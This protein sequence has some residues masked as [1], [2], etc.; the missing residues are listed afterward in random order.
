M[1]LFKLKSLF[2]K[3]C[4][5]AFLADD[6]IGICLFPN[7]S[8]FLKKRKDGRIKRETRLMKKHSFLSYLFWTATA[9]LIGITASSATAAAAKTARRYIASAGT[10]FTYEAE[11]LPYSVIEKTAI[12]KPALS[13][14]GYLA[15]D[16][17]TGEIILEKN[18]SKQFPIASITK[19]MTALVSLETIDQSQIA[20][21][22]PEALIGENP[23]IKGLSEGE[24]IST[25]SLLYP[26]LL[27]SSNAAAK[28]LADHIGTKNFLNRMNGETESIGMPKT[29][30]A[31]SSGLS[32]R[33][34]STPED[35]FKLVSHI[36]K[37]KKQILDI[38]R[39]KEWE[40][41]MR[42]WANG[43]KFSGLENFL[44]GKTGYTDSAGKTFAGI[45]SLPSAES[46]QRK[47]AVVI[48]KSKDRDDDVVKILDY[49]K[50]K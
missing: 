32:S 28:T 44:G 25:S 37:N 11:P 40:E 27:E 35:L 10:T 49:L 36:F 8:V 47:I 4:L 5:N 2:R 43:D 46:E 3:D 12:K 14:E 23:S 7:H 50:N 26:L 31:D 33:N 30:F 16:I 1:S 34:V 9:V 15:A 48:L 45:F 6:V 39:K 41:G 38:T 29:F 42:K 21:V 19:L 17:Q 13:A 24:V 20:I 18:K 22:P